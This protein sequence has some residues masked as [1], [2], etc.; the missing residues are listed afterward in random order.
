MPNT[1]VAIGQGVISYAMSAN[2]CAED[3]GTLLSALA[4]AGLLVELGGKLNRCGD[5]SCRLWTSFVYL[6]IE[7]LAD[8]GVQIGLPRETSFENGSPNSSR[9]WTNGSRKP[10]TSWSLEETKFAARRVLTIAG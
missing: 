8:S 1:P 3:E 10:A 5:R 4:K 9:C 2:C 7:A 6:F